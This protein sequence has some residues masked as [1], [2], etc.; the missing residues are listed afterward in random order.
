MTAYK[1]RMC[2][3]GTFIV[4]MAINNLRPALQKVLT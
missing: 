4:R 1:I 2:E 3:W